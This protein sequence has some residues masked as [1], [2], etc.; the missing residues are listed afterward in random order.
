MGASYQSVEMKAKMLEKEKE[1]EKEYL[2]YKKVVEFNELMNKII[3][4]HK[5]EKKYNL[6]I[7]YYDEHLRDEEEN[8]DNCSFIE[9]NINGT[10]YGCHNF[11]LF[12][13]VCE[14]IKNNQ[15]QFIL[16]SSGSAAKKIYDY[17]SNI[18]EIRE[19]F[20]YCWLKDKY[21]PLMDQYPKLKGIYNVFSELKEKLYDIN[22]IKM[23]NIQSSNL[24]MFEDYSRIYIKLHYEFIRKYSL[25]KILKS[26]NLNET[27]FYASLQ[28]NIHI[29]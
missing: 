15:K 28:K 19:Y 6:N 4:K 7:I 10:F 20:I 29:F 9:M 27:E 17:C 24:I 16:I 2:K 13:L 11:K 12:K 21:M 22:E 1:K 23:D 26:K 25:Y 3:K 18:K 5:N 14:K 8:S